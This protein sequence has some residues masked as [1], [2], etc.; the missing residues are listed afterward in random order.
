MI[1]DVLFCFCLLST[2]KAFPGIPSVGYQ[3]PQFLLKPFDIKKR[4][5]KHQLLKSIGKNFILSKLDKTCLII[6][7]F[8]ILV[9]LV[10]TKRWAKLIAELTVITSR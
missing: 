9:F 3:F 5:I 10:S 1:L 2:F 6:S 8:S 7:V 4:K